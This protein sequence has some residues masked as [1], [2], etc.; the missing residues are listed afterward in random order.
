M[1]SQTLKIPARVFSLPGYR[2]PGRRRSVRAMKQTANADRERALRYTAAE[3]EESMLTLFGGFPSLCGFSIQDRPGNAAG[4]EALE[5]GLFLT[6]VGLYPLPN[7]EEAKFICQEIRDTLAQLLEERPQ[8]RELL[9]GR[10]FA[11]SLH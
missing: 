3:L 9:S 2:A 11:R 4:S 1:S 5:G 10:T 6:D 8:A 7:I